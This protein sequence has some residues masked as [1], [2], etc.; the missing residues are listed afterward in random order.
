[1]DKVSNTIFSF[2]EAVGDYNDVDCKDDN[3][4]HGKPSHD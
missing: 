3:S 4:E 2:A 1:M